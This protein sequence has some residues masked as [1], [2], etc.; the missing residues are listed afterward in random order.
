MLD[1]LATHK[2]SD[3][4]YVSHVFVDGGWNVFASVIYEC[5]NFENGFLLFGRASALE[6]SGLSS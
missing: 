4:E 5:L 3:L 6:I 1:G 2:T